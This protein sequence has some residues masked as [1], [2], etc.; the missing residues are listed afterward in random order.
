MLFF[1]N[2]GKY[3]TL[4]PKPNQ[5]NKEAYLPKILLIMVNGNRSITY[6]DSNAASKVPLQKVTETSNTS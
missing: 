2:V 6:T 1:V 3:K 4:L 5:V